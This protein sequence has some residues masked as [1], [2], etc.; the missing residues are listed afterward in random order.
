MYNDDSMKKFSP[1]IIGIGA[2]YAG[3]G[4]VSELLAA[5]PAVADTLPVL[6][7]FNT[8][9]YTKKGL[10]WY[11]ATLKQ[12]VKAGLMIGECSPGYLV[13]PGTAE[14][15]VSAYPTAKLFVV[16][17]HPLAR[18]VAAYAATLGEQRPR[19]GACAEYLSVHDELQRQSYYG[20]WL[21]EY[22]AY[23]TSLNLHIILYE[24]L[25]RE[26]LKTIQGLYR[27]LEIDH[28]YIPK[29]LKAFAPPPDEPKHRSLLSKLIHFFVLLYK[30]ATDKPAVPVVA[31]FNVAHYLSNEEQM[32]FEAGFVPD[33][34]ILSEFMHQNMVATWDLGQVTEATAHA[35]PPGV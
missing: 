15:I 30:R 19:P 16:L 28:E 6:N 14:R 4:A 8:T 29:R 33:A 21:A 17:R 22:F 5:H 2:S 32:L 23:Y 34:T 7:F 3:L 11:E 25:E 12:D 31:P 18:A 20:A 26:P 13:T 10:A 27:F 9:A 24:D 1:D 35:V